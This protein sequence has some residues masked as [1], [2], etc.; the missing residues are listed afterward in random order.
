MKREFNITAWQSLHLFKYYLSL[1]LPWWGKAYTEISFV[2]FSG[3]ERHRL[4]P[5]PFPIPEH[6]QP[7]PASAPAPAQQHQSPG[8]HRRDLAI[9]QHL[10]GTQ[11][12]YNSNS[13]K[14]SITTLWI[15]ILE[16]IQWS[17]LWRRSSATDYT[18]PSYTWARRAVIHCRTIALVKYSVSYAGIQLPTW[19]ASSSPRDRASKTWSDS[20]RS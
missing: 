1:S 15:I 11:S 7:L 18:L 13:L 17:T 10:Q 4:N 5:H 2:K 9:Q 16:K 3:Q 19:F 20:P 14:Y 8:C 12:T 6:Q